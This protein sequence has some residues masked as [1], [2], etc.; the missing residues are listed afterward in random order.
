MP[1]PDRCRWI[2]L[3]DAIENF[4]SETHSTESAKHIKPLH[5]HIA[6]RLVLEG[7]FHPDNVTPRPPF[8][9]EKTKT[10]YFLHYVSSEGEGRESTLLGGLKTKRVDVVVAK[11]GIGPVIAISVKGTIKAFRNLTNRMEE[12]VGDCT[13]LHLSYPALV[14]GFLH[15]LKANRESKSVE[16]SD[17]FVHTNDRIADHIV[18]YHDVMSRLTGRNDVR[19]EVSRYEAVSILAANAQRNQHGEIF[20]SYPQ[21]DSPLH[22]NRFMRDLYRNYDERFVYAAP[23]LSSTTRRLEWRSDSLA[24]TD[25]NITDFPTR[26]KG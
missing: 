22:F 7:G 15:V 4:V 6:C 16:P 8:T 20:E 23:A 17:V 26:T 14:Y 2:T 12:A 19:A 24:L 21:Q 25:L 18:R 13:N 11:Q 3:N 1:R 10:G 5:W 9:A